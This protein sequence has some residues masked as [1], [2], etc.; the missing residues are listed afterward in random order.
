V[1]ERLHTERLHTERLLLRPLTM[2]DVD[3][4]VGLNSEPE[5]M[6]YL[7]GGRPSTRDEVAQYIP[8]HLGTRW[9][10][11]VR[12]TGEFVCWF[13]LAVSGDG[14]YEVGYCL[15]REVWERVWRRKGRRP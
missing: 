13:A 12:E 6:R 10:A 5:V 9:T 4:L 7:T 8:R 1:I 3:L 2:E 14:D 15:R 11:F